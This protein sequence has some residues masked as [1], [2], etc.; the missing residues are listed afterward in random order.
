MPAAK[1][2]RAPSL[3]GLAER[4]IE[5]LVVEHGVARNTQNAY[6]RDLQLYLRD[7]DARGI[8][9]ARA[10]KEADVAGFLARLRTAE[11]ADGR[12]YSDATVARALAAVRGFHRWLVREG[13]ATAD[14]S[15]SIGSVRIP[16]LAPKA[17]SVE[18]VERLLESVPAEGPV[19][20]RDRAML[21]VLYACGLRI[22]ELTGLDVDD[23][24][25]DDGTVRCFGKGSKE[26]IVPIGRLARRAVAAYLT[27]E[28][29]ALAKARGEH[30]MFVNQRGRRLT[31]QGCWKILKHYAEDRAKLAAKVTPHTLRHSFATHLLDRGADIRVVQELLGHASVST[32][33]VYT[34]VS[35]EKLREIYYS[36]HPRS[37]RAPARR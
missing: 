29:P 2:S 6:R 19:A 34:L 32:T 11:Y 25:L 31:R 12:R 7:L 33:Q 22:S 18:D 23:V 14:P 20:R 36:S 35:Q 16:R 30:A 15:A 24:D 10:V 13:H 5:N 9:G 3:D 8:G 21:E 28:R 1:P 17:L 4:Y 27:Q 26:R 37:G